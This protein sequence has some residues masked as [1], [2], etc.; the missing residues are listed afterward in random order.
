[1]SKQFEEAKKAYLKKDPRKLAEF[2]RTNQL[3]PE[4]AEFVAMALAGEVKVQ[5]GRSERGATRDIYYSYLE[6]RTGGHLLHELFGKGATPTKAEIY[7]TLA[8]LYGYSDEDSVKKAII[9]AKA[10]RPSG[11]YDEQGDLVDCEQ[12]KLAMDEVA[13]RADWA[14]NQGRPYAITIAKEQF[15]WMVKNWCPDMAHCLDLIDQ[16]VIIEIDQDTGKSRVVRRHEGEKVCTYDEINPETGKRRV[17]VETGSTKQYYEDPK[18]TDEMLN[19]IRAA[20]R[21]TIKK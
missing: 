6:I 18:I 9:R 12:S 15:S 5:D 17:V 1:M 2:V 10:R 3:T 19:E 13:K 16:D 4:Q 7:R 21:D 8:D 14:N 11:V 20:I